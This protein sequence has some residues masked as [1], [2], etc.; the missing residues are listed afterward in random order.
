MAAA[1]GNGGGGGG[2]TANDLQNVFAAGANQSQAFEQ[3]LMMAKRSRKLLG[4]WD[5]GIFGKGFVRVIMKNL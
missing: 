3:Y 4:F 1:A 5:L 2:M